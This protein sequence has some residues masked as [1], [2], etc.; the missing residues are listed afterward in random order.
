[1]IPSEIIHADQNGDAVIGKNLKIK[2]TTELSGGLKAIHEYSFTDNGDICKLGVFFETYLS[3]VD[4]YNFIGYLTNSDGEEQLCFG[5]Y[6]IENGQ[7]KDIYAC[8][9]Y[10]TQYIPAIQSWSSFDNTSSYDSVA[11]EG[12]TQRKIYVHTLMMQMLLSIVLKLK[13]HLL[14]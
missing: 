12:R 2:G 6:F 10:D 1:M 5:Q 9:F 8:Y 4:A 14:I 13:N 7:L 11:L 3:L